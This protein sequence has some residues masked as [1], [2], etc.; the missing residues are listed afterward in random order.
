MEFFPSCDSPIDIVSVIYELNIIESVTALRNRLEQFMTNECGGI[1]ITNAIGNNDLLCNAFNPH[2]SMRERILDRIVLRECCADMMSVIFD[3]D[4]RR[5]NVQVNI[6]K[7]EFGTECLKIIYNA[8]LRS[9]DVRLFQ[10][11]IIHE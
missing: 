2:L 10:I 1:V 3:L 8:E 7:Y 11:N 9:V 4:N 5:Q 6:Y